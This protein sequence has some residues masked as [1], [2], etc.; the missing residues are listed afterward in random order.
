MLLI[1]YVHLFA[2]LGYILMF[3]NSFFIIFI[4]NLNSGRL[5]YFDANFFN[6]HGDNFVSLAV[7]FC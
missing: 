1:L 7:G 2:V 5:H 6:L 4:E 3:L